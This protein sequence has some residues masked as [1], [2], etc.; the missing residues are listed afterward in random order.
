MIKQK[1]L[2]LL[3]ITLRKNAIPTTFEHPGYINIPYRSYDVTIG[4]D[5]A[6]ISSIAEGEYCTELNIQC[7]S[8]SKTEIEGVQLQLTK[9]DTYQ[10][11]YKQII[12]SVAMMYDLIDKHIE[13]HGFN[14]ADL[15]AQCFGD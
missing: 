15:N 10:S 1:H 3:S 12:H 7:D 8:G 11:V 9:D 5:G 4:L 13:S 2:A 14:P 6:A